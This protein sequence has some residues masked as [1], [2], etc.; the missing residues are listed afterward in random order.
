MKIRLTESQL[1]TC[2][3]EVIKEVDMCGCEECMINES[4]SSTDKNELKSMVK[5][6]IKDF[7]DVNRSTDLE[8]KISD[9][10]KKTLK[11]DKEIEKYLVELTRNV[12]VQMYKNLYTRK[13]F[14][15]SDLKNAA[16]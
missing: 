6:E 12:L 5:K 3:K 11:N 2:F 7:L 9:I 13:S 1:I 14:W 10:V 16:N 8:R 4:I 15:T